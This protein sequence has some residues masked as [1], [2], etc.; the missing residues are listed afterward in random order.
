MYL[1]ISKKLCCPNTKFWLMIISSKND[2]P[3]GE[4]QPRPSPPRKKKPLLL[5]FVVLALSSEMEKPSEAEI[6]FFPL[7][8]LWEIYFI[9]L[10]AR[11]PMILCECHLDL[12]LSHFGHRTNGKLKTI[13]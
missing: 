10:I 13:Q 8:F 6:Y 2:I 4:K 11:A 3:G 9:F 12:Q 7:H 5:T 1:F